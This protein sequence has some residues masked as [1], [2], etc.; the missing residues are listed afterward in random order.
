MAQ[1]IVDTMN[2]DAELSP[3][4][5]GIRILFKVIGLSYDKEAVK[6][7]V[8]GSYLTD[9]SV[10]SKAMTSKQGEKPLFL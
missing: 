8:P 9:E 4:G 6:T 2:S 3:S 10:I 5:T 1:D 7:A